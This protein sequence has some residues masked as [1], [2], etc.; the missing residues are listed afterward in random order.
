MHGEK[1]ISNQDVS[2]LKLKMIDYIISAKN[3]EKDV[4][5]QKMDQSESFQE[6]INFAMVMLINLFCY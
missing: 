2:L 4:V 6:R 3:V 5:S 1:K